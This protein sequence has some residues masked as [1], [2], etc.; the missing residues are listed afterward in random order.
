MLSG[1][2]KVF[3]TS[4]SG[5]DRILRIVRR[6]QAFGELAMIEGKDRFVTVQTL[7]DCDVLRLARKDFVEFGNKHTWVLWTLLAAF[8][9]RIRRKN[10]DML[11]L[12]F[13]D[14]PYRLLHVLSELVEQHGE[15]GPDGWKIT[16]SLSPLDLASMVGTSTESIAHLLG[17]YESDGLLKRAGNNWIVPDP[18]ALTKIIEYAAQQDV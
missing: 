10:D 1:S 9:E 14:V 11:D 5:Q 2:A 15:K 6:G 4:E 16:M 3:Q 13:R 17:R 18:Q 12:A 7:E 8:A